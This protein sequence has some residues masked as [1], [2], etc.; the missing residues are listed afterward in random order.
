MIIK[1]KHNFIIYP[2]FRIYTIL[3]IWKNFHKVVISGE[4]IDK[5]L[6]VLLLSNHVSWWDGI[7]VMYLNIKYFNRKFHFMMLEDQI[8]KFRITNQVG[9]YSVKKGSRSIIETLRYTNEILS[10]KGNLVLIF[11]QGD[12]QSVYNGII[13]FEKGVEKILRDNSGK[14]QVF[15]IAN[16][17]DYFS[18]EKPTLFIYFKELTTSETSLDEIEKEYNT[19]YSF[20]I[21][22][23]ISKSDIQ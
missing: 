7:W 21:S 16:L 18:K 8:K 3:K 19:F 11:P 20:C 17:V 12:I 22:E 4:L 5:N 2:Y 9:G 6:P 13:R 1:S 10:D 15:L 14:I 23:N